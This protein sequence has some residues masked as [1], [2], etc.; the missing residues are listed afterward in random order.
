MLREVRLV[1]RL[2]GRKQQRFENAQLLAPVGRRQ[3]RH[4][5]GQPVRRPLGRDRLGVAARPLPLRSTVVGLD[6]PWP[7]SASRRT[8]RR[9]GRSASAAPCAS[10]SCEDSSTRMNAPATIIRRLR[11]LALSRPR[12]QSAPGLAPP[13]VDRRERRRLPDLDQPFARHL[14]RR[15]ERAGERRAAKLGRRQVLL[16]EQIELHPAAR[17]RCAD[18]LL[19][20]RCAHP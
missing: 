19:Q 5:R 4:V 7:C 1:E 3:R 10:P 20:P 9:G 2:G 8:P 12:S 14:Q 17:R 16:E 18:Q 11:R 13:H 15:A 6:S